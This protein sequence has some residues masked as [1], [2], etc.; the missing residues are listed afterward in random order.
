MDKNSRSMTVKS[1]HACVCTN[2]LQT[3]AC[4]HENAIDVSVEIIYSLHV[5]QV[6]G[7]IT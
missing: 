5:G 1:E 3:R 6:L 2:V 7:N 4:S